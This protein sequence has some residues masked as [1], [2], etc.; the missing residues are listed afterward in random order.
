M[1]ERRNC[2]NSGI[3]LP[4]L[5]IGC[6]AY[7]GGDY[8]GPQDQK[9]IQ[10][11]VNRALD[12]GINYFDTAEAYNDGRSEEALGLALKG[13]RQ[14]AIIG[15]KVIP[16]NT[17][18]STLRQH[19]EA[20]LR[21]L[22]SDTID[23]YM[24]HWPIVDHSVEDAFA[25]LETLK[26]EGKVRSIGVSNFGAHQL[27]EALDTGSRIDV[28]Q[29]C[30]NLLS[31]AIEVELMPLCSRRGIGILAYMPLLQG[32]LTG[33]FHSADEIP[34]YRWRTRHFRGDRAGSRH[35]EAG[36]EEETFTAIK[37]IREIALEL[38]VPMAQ[39]ALAWILSRPEITCV[40]AGIRTVAQLEENVASAGLRLSPDV[41]D[42]LNQLTEP[43]LRKLGASPDYFQ[44][45]HDSRIR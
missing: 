23:I 9:D 41:I 21:R 39:V 32:L 10:A 1:I 36:A 2:G 3:T 6:W 43:L 38:Q 35:G 25:T 33:K 30:Y 29:L 31:R 44:A 11:I 24:V 34:M 7:G 14:E 13:R 15:T 37:G 4:V 20:S 27:H 18:P 17:E 12:R 19:C 42:R 40:L 16:S 45:S 22:Q 8:W 28:N 26:A 5:G